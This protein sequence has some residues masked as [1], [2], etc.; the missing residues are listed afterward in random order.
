[1]EIKQVNSDSTKI[2]ELTTEELK[3]ISGG[4][5]WLKALISII[6]LVIPSNTSTDKHDN[7]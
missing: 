1:M 3:T 6:M 2:R 5:A 4:N 7:K